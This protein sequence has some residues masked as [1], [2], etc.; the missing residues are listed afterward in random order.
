ME[1]DIVESNPQGIDDVLNRSALNTRNI[2][3]TRGAGR[4]YTNGSVK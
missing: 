2:D 4:P 3:E 1:C